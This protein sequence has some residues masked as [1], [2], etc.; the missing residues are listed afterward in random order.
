MLTASVPTRHARLLAWV[1]EFRALCQPDAVVW[2]DGSQQENE[3]LCA[4]MV[5]S[6]TAVR[7]SV[8]VVG[9]VMT[10]T[11]TRPVTNG[12]ALLLRGCSQRRL[13]TRSKRVSPQRVT[14]R[15][16]V[17]SKR[18]ISVIHVRAMSVLRW[19]KRSTSV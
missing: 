16:A 1:E 8:L 12:T 6:G 5:A 3:R 15:V 17:S 2:C 18:S 11:A 10:A 4:A 13:R 19:P 14:C 7:L 9:A